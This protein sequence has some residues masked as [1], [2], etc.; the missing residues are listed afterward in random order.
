MYRNVV[1]DSARRLI[2]TAR[3]MHMSPGGTIVE[4]GALV[5]LALEAARTGDVETLDRAITAGVSPT[6]KN[7]RGD[8]LLMVASHHGHD[9]AVRVLL[10][11]GANPNEEDANGRTPLM[12]AAAFG[13]T[14]MVHLL[15][16]R[17]AC[18]DKR[19]ASGLR[20]IDIARA[21]GAVEAAAA[22]VAARLG[23]A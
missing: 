15:L 10:E 2:E 12:L 3:A 19:D 1:L 5:A 23:R 17:G 8:S 6:T 22:L 11:R 9:S 20:A 14:E 16:S 13:R 7:P 18:P 4:A 21:M